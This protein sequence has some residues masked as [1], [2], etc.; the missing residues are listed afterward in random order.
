M[1]LKSTQ[2]DT[3]GQKIFICHDPTWVKRLAGNSLK[4]LSGTLNAKM[5]ILPEGII[6]QLSDL[7]PNPVF[8]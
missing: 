2:I 4:N 5:L 6:L 8:R 1:E 3:F 7:R